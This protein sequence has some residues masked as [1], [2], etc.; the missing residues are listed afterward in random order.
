MA[1]QKQC[2]ASGS[3]S[4]KRSETFLSIKK[5]KKNVDTKFHVLYPEI[6]P[7]DIESPQSFHLSHDFVTEALKLIVPQRS[8]N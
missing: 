6:Y 3:L 7:W 2:I 1:Y 8:I 4:T 5:A